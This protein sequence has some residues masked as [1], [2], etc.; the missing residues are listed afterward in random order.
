VAYCW[1]DLWT[2]KREDVERKGTL[3]TW[4]NVQWYSLNVLFRYSRISTDVVFF[5]WEPPLVP[6]ARQYCILKRGTKPKTGVPFPSVSSSESGILILANFHFLY[7]NTGTPYK[8]K[9]FFTTMPRRRA[10]NNVSIKYIIYLIEFMSFFHG[11]VQLYPSDTDFEQDVLVQ[12]TPR[13]IEMHDDACVRLCI[14][15]NF[16]QT[17]TIVVD[18]KLPR[19]AQWKLR[20]LFLPISI[21]ERQQICSDCL[22]VGR[23]TH[24]G[25]D[26]RS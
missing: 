9:N 12:I 16:Q 15:S 7:Q 25:P 21:T 6:Q 14:H 23:W 19:L 24:S 4:W 18:P 10:I 11:R 3:T 8:T 1:E 20:T 17:D 5:T 2:R 13:D 22:D 26:R